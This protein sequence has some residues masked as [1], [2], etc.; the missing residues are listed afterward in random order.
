M[1]L[2]KASH[3]AWA[4]KWSSP[5]KINLFLHVVGQL[6]NGY[7]QLQT[8]FQ[9]LDYGDSI[10]FTQRSDA[11][12]TR[13]QGAQG[14][15]AVEDLVVRAAQLLRDEAAKHYRTALCGVDIQVEKCLPMGGGLGGGSS[16]AATTLLVLNQLWHCGFTP[17]EL[18]E[19]GLQL[20]ADV[21]VFVRGHSAWA[22]GVGDELF[23]L[24]L[25]ERHYVV[26]T[27]PIMVN[28]AKIF[29]SPELTRDSRISTMADFANGFG[30]NDCTAVVVNEYPEVAEVLDFI[31]RFGSARMSGTGASVFL[32]CDSLPQARAVAAAV[33]EKQA[34]WS[35]FTATG[36]ARSPL[37][38]QLESVSN[39]LAP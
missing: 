14:V 2:V 27:P 33:G 29:S 36:V 16:N 35:V 9:L 30:R 24:D 7:H 37:L 11:Q 28:T 38:A 3:D 22:E 31:G 21:P 18:A 19:L 13:S 17:D 23:F 12:I 4:I 10:R 32:A 15:A 5:A 26:A 20:G 39:A 34:N 1:A 8:V 25:P 6:S